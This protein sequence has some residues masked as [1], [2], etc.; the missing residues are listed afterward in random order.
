MQSCTSTQIQTIQNQAQTV[1][2][3]RELANDAADAC[4]Y[5]D[6]AA[7]NLAAILSAAEILADI[8]TDQQTEQGKRHALSLAVR[9]LIKTAKNEVETLAELHSFSLFETAADL[10]NEIFSQVHSAK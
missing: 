6:R 10:N 2:I 7:E 5:A 9:D 1:T 4:F 3:P 8:A